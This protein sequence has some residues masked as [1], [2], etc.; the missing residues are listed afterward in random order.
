MSSLIAEVVSYSFSRLPVFLPSNSSPRPGGRGSTR[1]PINREPDVGITSGMD[2]THGGRSAL[3]QDEYGARVEPSPPPWA[4]PKA[5]MGRAFGPRNGKELAVTPSNNR[6]RPP[7]FPS[8]RF[9]IHLLEPALG[10]SPGRASRVR[11]DRH[12]F[13]IRLGVGIDDRNQ[14]VIRFVMEE[15][16]GIVTPE[17]QR[18]PGGTGDQFPGRI[19]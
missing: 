5:D 16:L 7:V 14:H 10:D 6:S 9:R 3:Y 4:V 12:Q 18:D 1:A 17:G 8:S 15:H 13:E 2:P 11:T 19:V